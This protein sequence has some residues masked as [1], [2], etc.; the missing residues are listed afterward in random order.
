MSREQKEIR[1]DLDE[2]IEQLESYGIAHNDEY[3][4]LGDMVEATLLRFG[5]TQDRFKRFFNLK[6]CDC[7]K[8]KKWLN[9]IF[10]W[11][12]KEIEKE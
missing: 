10:T 2:V 5:I 4:G 12:K 6:E 1:E 11:H 3:V 7:N 9:S 8:R